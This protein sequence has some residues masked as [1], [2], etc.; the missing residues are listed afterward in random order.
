MAIAVVAAPAHARAAG[1][2]GG[3]GFGDHDRDDHSKA[4]ER[5][6][7][8]GLHDGENDAR[9]SRP[10]VIRLDGRARRDNDFRRGYERGYRESYD[11]AR[12]IVV[13]P[14]PFPQRAP[15]AIFDRRLPRGYQEPAYARGYS[16]GYRKGVDDGQD[17]DRYDPVRHGEYR[18][19]DKGY[20]RDYGPRDAY[21]NN[22]RAGFR[23]GYEDGYRGGANGRR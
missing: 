4:Y 14:G 3:I 23:Q 1:R 21:K 13:Q 22:Y 12:V 9:H 18:D 8:D 16:D 10:F 15:G 2:S 17:R 5:G 11:R 7:R 6:Y 20:Y 19:G